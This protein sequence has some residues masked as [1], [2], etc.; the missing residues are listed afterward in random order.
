[1]D[2]NFISL[3][4]SGYYFS[5]ETNDHVGSQAISPSS[6]TIFVHQMVMFVLYNTLFDVMGNL[7]SLIVF[8]F[9]HHRTTSVFALW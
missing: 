6:P 5:N 8:E 3:A 2:F 7:P 4:Y 9:I 1:M